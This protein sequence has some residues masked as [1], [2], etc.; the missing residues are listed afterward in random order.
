M[1]Q[2]ATGARPITTINQ[3]ISNQDHL[4]ACLKGL[5]SS[6]ESRLSF[7]MLNPLMKKIKKGKF[8]LPTL[9]KCKFDQFNSSAYS[10]KLE[11]HSI[12][13][14]DS[15][16]EY[17]GMALE[18]GSKTSR[19]QCL[20]FNSPNRPSTSSKIHLHE[21]KL[22]KSHKKGVEVQGPK[23]NKEEMKIMSERIA[24]GDKKVKTIIHIL[25][26]FE[27]QSIVEN[28]IDSQKLKIFRSKSRTFL[29]NV[30]SNYE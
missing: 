18:E 6:I 16:S 28:I 25:F 13:T 10:K 14:R 11:C 17:C 5:K 15:D 19:R 9:N 1:S 22:A 7:N 3:T 21:A 26:R 2:S 29:G 4:Q 23:L 30:M 20:V 8:A 24:A 27:E 12:S